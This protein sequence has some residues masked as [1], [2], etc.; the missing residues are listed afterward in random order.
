MLNLLRDEAVSW[1][2][3]PHIDPA[4]DFPSQEQ[5]RNGENTTVLVLNTENIFSVHRISFVVS[6]C[7]RHS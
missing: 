1:R 6:V 4:L 5:D 3:I 7:K 2:S